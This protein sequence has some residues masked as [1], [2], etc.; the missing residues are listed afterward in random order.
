MTPLFDG[1]SLDFWLL[2][3]GANPVF[4]SKLARFEQELALE[5]K[6]G[7]NVCDGDVGVGDGLERAQEDEEERLDW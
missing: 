6:E 5:E 1:W 4:P 3:A 7:D 2:P